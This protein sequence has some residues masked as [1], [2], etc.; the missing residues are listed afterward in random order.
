[1]NPGLTSGRKIKGAHLSQKARKG[2]G[3]WREALQTASNF[4]CFFAWQMT[5]P[6]F[7]FLLGLVSILLLLGFFYFLLCLKGC[8]GTAEGL[9]LLFFLAVAVWVRW[10][11]G[12]TGRRFQILHAHGKTPDKAHVLC[13]GAD[14][15][16]RSRRGYIPRDPEGAGRVDATQEAA[17]ASGLQSIWK[18]SSFWNEIEYRGRFVFQV[19]FIC[20]I[21][22]IWCI[23]TGCLCCN[24]TL[25]LEL[26][27]WFLGGA[28]SA[29]KMS[30]TSR[31]RPPQ[32][33]I[34]TP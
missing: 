11:V 14:P 28:H 20:I 21:I 19:L 29:D 24:K 17:Q 30:P 12:R 16:L 13:K 18:E 33:S 7:F 26:L 34:K 22:C 2:F 27:L 6:F 32:S 8:E 1:M 4:A 9:P 3:V 5:K 23:L 25:R 15:R 10:T 31:F